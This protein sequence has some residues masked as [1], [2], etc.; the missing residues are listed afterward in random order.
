MIAKVWVA[1]RE[2]PPE[3]RKVALMIEGKIYRFTEQQARRLLDQLTV[4][5]IEI[6]AP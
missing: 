5:V 1:G 4:A 2:G 3:G 6:G